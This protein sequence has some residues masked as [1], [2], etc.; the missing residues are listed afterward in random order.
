METKNRNV[1]LSQTQLGMYFESVRMGGCAY[2]RHYLYTLD[3]SLDMERLARAIEKTVQAH[4]Y[5]EVRISQDS[6]GAITQLIPPPSISPG[7]RENDRITMAR[8]S[9]Y[10]SAKEVWVSLSSKLRMRFFFRPLPPMMT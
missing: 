1:P 9:D 3:K 2:N 4:P 8:T 5:M 10:R 6:N 7:C